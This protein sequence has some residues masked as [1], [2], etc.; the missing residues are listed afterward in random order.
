M[1][2]SGAGD[3]LD[4]ARDSAVAPSPPKRQRFGEPKKFLPIAFVA[5][6]IVTLYCI[7]VSLH[8][9]P[10][11]QLGAWRRPG[12]VDQDARWRGVVETVVF[13]YLTALMLVCYVRSVLE[14]PGEIPENDAQWQYAP[15]D[16]G[17][18]S[19]GAFVPAGLQEMKRTGLRRHCKWCHK[20]KPDRCHHC[21]MCKSCV[22]K[23]DHHC[24]WI[25]NCVGFANYKFFF[26]L[27]FYAVSD[28]HLILWSMIESVQR[29]IADPDTPFSVLFF[30]F[31]GETL[32][33]F[34]SVLLG[35]F[36][37]FHIW[38]M[39]RA[40]TTIECCEKAMP[41]KDSEPTTN[42]SYDSSVY[43]LG[44]LGNIRA[45][46]GPNVLLW[47][48]PCARPAGDGLCFV[49]EETRLTKEMESGKG[50]R[51]RT[52]Q[53]TPRVPRRFMGEPGLAG[54]EPRWY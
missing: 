24:P 12:G 32:A 38:L 13:H 3:L 41:K 14:H 6:T 52:H 7:Y 33:L 50:I 5:F 29:C 47:F 8:C 16:A 30:T 27:L 19:P 2:L 20:Y 45:V 53:R 11:L 22:L 26:L 10:L 44:V 51:R 36:F 42:R 28:C 46:L 9:V 21:R 31:F 4:S 39:L 54:Y 25:Y 35:A 37:C 34:L 48:F 15:L 1:Q 18:I 43:D 17:H 49:S 23:M 40:M